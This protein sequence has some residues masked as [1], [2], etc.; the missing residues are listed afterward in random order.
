MKGVHVVSQQPWHPQ[1][2]WLLKAC[3]ACQNQLAWLQ[4]PHSS[5]LR[6]PETKHENFEQQLQ[7]TITSF[8]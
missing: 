7:A 6:A 1:E 2:G 8:Q 4:A 5:C 3:P